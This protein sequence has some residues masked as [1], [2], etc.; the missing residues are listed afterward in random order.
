MLQR[1]NKLNQIDMPAAYLWVDFVNSLRE[2][3]F[4]ER[5]LAIDIN[6]IRA[7]GL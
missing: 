2:T 4:I 7:K 1:L 5:Y 6:A 3:D